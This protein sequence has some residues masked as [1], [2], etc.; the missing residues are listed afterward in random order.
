MSV[1]SWSS[2]SIR[3]ALIEM[4]WDTAAR[5]CSICCISRCTSRGRTSLR[6]GVGA[7]AVMDRDAM[8]PYMFAA[9]AGHPM[10]YFRWRPI[11]CTY[12]Y[13]LVAKPYEPG[14]IFCLDVG[15][16]RGCER[17]ATRYSSRAAR[18][19]RAACGDVRDL[20][21]RNGLCC[22]CSSRPCSGEMVRSRSLS[23]M[24]GSRAWL[25]SSPGRWPDNASRN[26][27]FRSRDPISSAR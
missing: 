10:K 18:V 14:K 26:A 20:S 27:A 2:S 11:A 5:R 23:R 8:I 25:V 24:T 22:S 4:R 1:G 6:R 13:L 17:A 16:C 15:E 12:Q 21:R 7:F 19:R 9:D 3:R